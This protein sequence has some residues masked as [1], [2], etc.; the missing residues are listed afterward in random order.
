WPRRARSSSVLGGR[1]RLRSRR[2][3]CPTSGSSIRPP[4]AP[5][6]RARRTRPMSRRS[7]DAA[8]ARDDAPMYLFAV[9][10]E[11][12][13]Q[14]VIDRVLLYAAEQPVQAEAVARDFYLADGKSPLRYR[15]S[16]QPV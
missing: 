14:V 9:V 1:P 15:F 4:A 3:A 5:F 7:S 2:P 12:P 8:R 13:R 10:V 6:G 16:A 11:D